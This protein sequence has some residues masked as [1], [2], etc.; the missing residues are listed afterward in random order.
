MT[1]PLCRIERKE[2]LFGVLVCRH[3]GR[4]G[5]SVEGEA[6]RLQSFLEIVCKRTIPRKRVRGG[7]G[8]NGEEASWSS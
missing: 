2:L 6:E 1:G 7:R 3:E 4:V 5:D 8:L